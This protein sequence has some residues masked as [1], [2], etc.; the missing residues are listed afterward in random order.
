MMTPLKTDPMID[1]RPTQA[2]PSAPPAPGGRKGD[3]KAAS[4]TWQ[5]KY[6][7]RRVKQA[8][9]T[10]DEALFAAKGMS[11][12]F[13]EQIALAAEL[14]GVPQEQ[15]RAEAIKSRKS[16]TLEV[17]APLKDRSGG[18]RSVVVERRIVRRP[19]MTRRI[20]V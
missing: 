12:D 18:V 17:R 14:M 8:L 6:G 7:R 5:T 15:V 11:D 13:N 2:H 1:S 19:A 3:S 20:G 10:L 16:T 4:K 9:P